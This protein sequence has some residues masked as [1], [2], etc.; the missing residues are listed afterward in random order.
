MVVGCPI[1]NEVESNKLKKNAINLANK[2]KSNKDLILFFKKSL[3]FLETYCAKKG[4]HQGY[5]LRLTCT[6]CH[7]LAMLYY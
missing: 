1:Y 3:E 5:G 4:L 2:V 7:Y 6:S